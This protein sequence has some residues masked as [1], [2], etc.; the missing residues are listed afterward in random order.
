MDYDANNGGQKYS[1]HAQNKCISFRQ[2]PTT[3]S[4]TFQWMGRKAVN[5]QLTDG[6]SVH[7]RHSE[8]K[9][10]YRINICKWRKQSRNFREKLFALAIGYNNYTDQ[11]KFVPVNLTLDSSTVL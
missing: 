4:F 10:K 8:E 5:F 9:Q 6:G 7:R 11:Q 2:K 3:F 1:G